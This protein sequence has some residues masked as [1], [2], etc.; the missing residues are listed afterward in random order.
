MRQQIKLSLYLLLLVVGASAFSVPS[1]ATKVVSSPLFQRNVYLQAEIS[2]NHPLS[3]RKENDSIQ[4]NPL[5]HSSRLLGK[6]RR[7]TAIFCTSLLFWIGAAGLRTS[8][9]NASTESASAAPSA[10]QSRNMLS[11][12]IDQIVDRYVKNHMFD[13]DVY[14]PVESTYR[15]AVNDK[16][17]GTHPRSISEITSSAL[18]QSGVK[19]DKKTSITGIGGV[20]LGGIGFLQRRGLSESTAILLLAG[21]FVVAGPIAFLTIGMMVGNQSKRQI[22]SVMK[23]RYGDTYT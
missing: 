13:D 20:M 21:S 3:L 6:I 7:L 8:P 15:E 16:I 5:V 2:G 14:D 11:L 22:N 10:P 4:D 12:S 19:A 9:S 18:G 23:K 1:R 17:Q